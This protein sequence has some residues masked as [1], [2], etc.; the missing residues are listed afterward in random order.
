MA[1]MVGAQKGRR[2]ILRVKSGGSWGQRWQAKTDTTHQQECVHCTLNKS[3]GLQV[4][5]KLCDTRV[6]HHQL[7]AQAEHLLQQCAVHLRLRTTR[8][9]DRCR[10]FCQL[11]ALNDGAALLLAGAASRG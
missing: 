9:H 6:Q 4:L 8:C 3:S 2:C 5:Q 11:V 10:G 1:A 7:L